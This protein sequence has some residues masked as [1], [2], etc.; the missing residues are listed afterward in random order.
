M[1]VLRTPCV[2]TSTT[3]V[4]AVRLFG[5]VEDKPTVGR[6]RLFFRTCHLIVGVT[7]VR[8]YK[9]MRRST[10]NTMGRVDASLTGLSSGEHTVRTSRPYVEQRSVG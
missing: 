7:F 6:I 3:R 5:G 8:D 4:P 9:V 10:T 2:C 1:P